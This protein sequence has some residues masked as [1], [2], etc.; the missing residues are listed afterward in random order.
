MAKWRAELRSVEDAILRAAPARYSNG[1]HGC[2]IEAAARSRSVPADLKRQRKYLR[3]S[4]Q[5][6]RMMADAVQ[7]APVA[8]APPPVESAPLPCESAPETVMLSHVLGALQ[9]IA[10]DGI[11]DAAMLAREADRIEATAERMRDAMP[12]YSATCATVAR[13]LRALA[14]PALDDD[15]TIPA[16]LDGLD[17]AELDDM[18]EF[19]RAGGIAQPIAPAYRDDAPRATPTPSLRISPSDPR[20]RIPA[21]FAPV[22]LLQA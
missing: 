5:G 2:D 8:S 9:R 7:P 19:E 6:A 14:D 18:V 20:A 11:P 15:E 4:L 17:V 22:Y 16:P 12:D 1:R 13:D 10:P 3:A 21:R